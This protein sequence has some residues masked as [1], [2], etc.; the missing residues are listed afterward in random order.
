MELRRGGGRQSNTRAVRPG[1]ADMKEFRGKVAVVTGAARDK[2]R[3]MAERFA[4]EGMRVV[5]ADIEQRAP[6]EA[7]REMPSS[8][9]C[10]CDLHRSLTCS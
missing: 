5:L 8:W 7:E 10:V 1:S 4:A 2:G 9:P 6:A 3:A